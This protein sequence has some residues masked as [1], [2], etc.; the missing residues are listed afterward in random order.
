VTPAEPY[1][2]YQPEKE[3]PIS[4]DP[5]GS[6]AM[7]EYEEKIEEVDSVQDALVRDAVILLTSMPFVSFYYLGIPLSA[8]FISAVM[9]EM[10][11]DQAEK[12][13]GT[14]SSTREGV[15]DMITRYSGIGPHRYFNLFTW[16][17][18]LMYEARV[19]LLRVTYLFAPVL[20]FIYYAYEYQT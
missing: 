12:V 6:E 13:D 18:F 19:W 14:R 20:P 2:W 15:D 17:G 10:G 5:Y 16:D 8:A 3:N 1:S 7:L 4:I 9:K 11:Y